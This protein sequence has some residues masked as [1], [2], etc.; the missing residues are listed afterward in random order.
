MA[1]YCM[2]ELPRAAVRTTPLFTSLVI[3]HMCLMDAP[4][5]PRIKGQGTWLFGVYQCQEDFYKK[6]TSVFNPFEQ[7]DFMKFIQ[8]RAEEP[9]N[10]NVKDST[11]VNIE[12]DQDSKESNNPDEMRAGVQSGKIYYARFTIIPNLYTALNIDPKNSLRARG[13]FN[14]SEKDQSDSNS[15]RSSGDGG[16]GALASGDG[17]RLDSERGRLSRERSSSPEVSTL[18]TSYWSMPW[19]STVCRETYTNV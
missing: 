3:W 2:F 5:K 16:A 17:S 6:P 18:A 7:R 4:V 19:A 12:D 14:T 9:D 11:P 8:A 1:E 13:A 15:G 10:M